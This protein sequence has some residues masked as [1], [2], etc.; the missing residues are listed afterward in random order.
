MSSVE[1]SIFVVVSFINFRYS[2]VLMNCLSSDRDFYPRQDDL[3]GKKQRNYNK[4]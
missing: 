1:D 4:N 3:R 2:T